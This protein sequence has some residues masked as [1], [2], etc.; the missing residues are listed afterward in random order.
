MVQID[1]ALRVHSTGNGMSGMVGGLTVPL[2]L[3][4]FLVYFLAK[5]MGGRAPL[6]AIVVAPVVGVGS[7]I[8]G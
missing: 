6:W 7:M 3:P 4:V 2:Y 1:A 5:L 8:L